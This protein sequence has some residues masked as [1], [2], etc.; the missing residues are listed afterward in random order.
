MGRK[1][2]A[3]DQ[4]CSAEPSADVRLGNDPL[5]FPECVEPRPDASKDTPRV[6]ASQCD[7]VLAHVAKAEVRNG[8][9]HKTAAA[10]WQSLHKSRQVTAKVDLKDL[11][12]P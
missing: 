11:R 7:M 6:R 4:Q 5:F 2:S 9:A 1:E 12:L 10:A 3:K 8:V